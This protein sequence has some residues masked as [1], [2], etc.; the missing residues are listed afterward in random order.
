MAHH[1]CR[2]TPKKLAFACYL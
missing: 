1:C 2:V